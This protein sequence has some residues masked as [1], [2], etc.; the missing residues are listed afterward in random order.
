[1]YLETVGSA[2]AI[3]HVV[4]TVSHCEIQFDLEQQN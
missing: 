4:T 2:E 3:P 1:M